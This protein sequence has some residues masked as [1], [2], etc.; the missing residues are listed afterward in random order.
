MVINNNMIQFN[1]KV[2]QQQTI[3]DSQTTY[4]ILYI[5]IT[6]S[7]AYKSANSFV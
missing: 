2:I 1:T 7:Y 4:Y 5:F 3:N 6:M